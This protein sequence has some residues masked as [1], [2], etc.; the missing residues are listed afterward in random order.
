MTHRTD[1]NQSERFTPEGGD[2]CPSFETLSVFF[3]QELNSD[4]FAAVNTHI[5]TCASCQR[6]LTDLSLLRSS[7]RVSSPAIGTRSF[8][9]R[10]SDSDTQ[11]ARTSK[12]PRRLRSF[13]IF[14]VAAALA[15]VLLL[16]LIAGERISVDDEQSAVESPDR[17]VLI[18]DGTPFTADGEDAQFGAASSGSM[19]ETNEDDSVSEQSGSEAS[20]WTGWRFAQGFALLA[21]LAVLVI[22]FGRRHANLT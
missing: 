8:A 22:W 19:N 16:A 1:D 17:Q 3:D 9:I 13:P 6:A 12:L 7:L 20:F 2:D 18:I 21:A 10:D 4:V 11:N 15:A 5:S 14:P